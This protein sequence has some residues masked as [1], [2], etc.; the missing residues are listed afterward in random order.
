[1]DLA[2]S[3]IFLLSRGAEVRNWEAA[4]W[5]CAV[6]VLRWQ[7]TTLRAVTTVTE[8]QYGLKSRSLGLVHSC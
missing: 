2:F 4:W 5:H 8:A 3:P 1:M 7:R 6:L